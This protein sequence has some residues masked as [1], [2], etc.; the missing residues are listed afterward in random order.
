MLKNVRT[1]VVE[2]LIRRLGTMCATVLVAHGV[3]GNIASQVA[4]ILFALGL[5]AVDLANS[6][7][8]RKP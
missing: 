7:W 3:D 2:P 1:E 4:D 5:V 8:A 6:Y